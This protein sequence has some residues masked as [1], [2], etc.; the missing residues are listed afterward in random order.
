MTAA[1]PFLQLETAVSGAR[2]HLACVE[3]ISLLDHWARLAAKGYPRRE[4]IDPVEFVPALPFIW[5]LDYERDTGRFRSRLAGDA[6]RDL[7][8]KNMTGTYLEDILAPHDFDWAN[9]MFKRSL[10]APA[11]LAVR[12]RIFTHR[13]EPGFGERLALPLFDAEGQGAGLIG[14]AFRAFDLNAS[15]LPKNAAER[16]LAVFPLNSGAPE[17][18]QQ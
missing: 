13:R 12:G 14:V 3:T 9:G 2:S 18:V 10:T 16:L 4:A 5:I 6:V 1:T 17:I 15:N 8:R 7:Y 11:I